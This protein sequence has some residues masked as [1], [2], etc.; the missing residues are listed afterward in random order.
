MIDNNN[1]C[2][3][4]SVVIRNT[5]YNNNINVRDGT[6]FDGR[7]SHNG[8]DTIPDTDQENGCCMDNEVPVL[9]RVLHCGMLRVEYH[10]K[11]YNSSTISVIMTIMMVDNNQVQA[12]DDIISMIVTC[13]HNTD[14]DVEYESTHL[15][16][17]SNSF[18]CNYFDRVSPS[19]LSQKQVHQ[20]TNI[21]LPL[22]LLQKQVQVLV[23]VLVQIQI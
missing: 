21:I 20:S 4:R 23:Q 14:S 9:V 10:I 7:I 18:D 17:K 19:S 12:C 15:F 8:V 3:H 22:S 13:V 2:T 1:G 16:I 6:A 11:A 5:I